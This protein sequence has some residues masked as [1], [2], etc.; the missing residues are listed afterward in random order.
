MDTKENI[1]DDHRITNSFTNARPPEL[2]EQKINEAIV[3][4]L[5]EN[6]ETIGDR[7]KTLYHSRIFKVNIHESR[8]FFAL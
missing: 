1:E 4:L 8:V 5:F 2:Q 6:G 7:K 3:Y